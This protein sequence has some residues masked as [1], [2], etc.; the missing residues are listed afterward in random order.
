MMGEREGYGRREVG[1]G[2]S[3]ECGVKR[4]GSGGGGR[5]YDD[6]VYHSV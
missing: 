6:C 3:A 1:V 2:G 5:V 4:D